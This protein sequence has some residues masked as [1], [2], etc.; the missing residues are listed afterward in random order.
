MQLVIEHE[1]WTNEE[2]GTS[3]KVAKVRWVNDPNRG[4]MQF[5]PVDP[6]EK[7]QIRSS[8]KGLID[9]IRSKK[10][11]A[12]P[13]DNKPSFDFGANAPDAGAAAAQPDAKAKF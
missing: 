3:G 8:F 10:A 5:A 9:D 7:I 12:A 6:A 1:D 13:A 4:R 2:K 11:K